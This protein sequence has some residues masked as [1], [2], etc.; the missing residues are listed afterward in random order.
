MN[1]SKL[2]PVLRL[3]DN[4]NK[5]VTISECIMVKAKLLSSVV[6]TCQWAHRAA[7]ASYFFEGIQEEGVLERSYAGSGL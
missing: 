5:K 7:N 4:A 3:P 6:K 2:I 1:C